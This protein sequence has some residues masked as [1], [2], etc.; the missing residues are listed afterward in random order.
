MTVNELWSHRIIDNQYHIP[1]WE[2]KI[3]QTYG[4]APMLLTREV[5]ERLKIYVKIFRSKLFDFLQSHPIQYF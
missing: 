3:A 2:H 4:P 1:V 5:F